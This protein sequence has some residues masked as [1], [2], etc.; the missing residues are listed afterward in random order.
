[1]EFGARSDHWPV[2]MQTI[3]PYLQEAIP[4]SVDGKTF[5][6]VLNVERTFWEKATILHM[7]AHYPEGKEIQS[8]QSRHYYDMYCLI[9]SEFCEL[10]RND[11]ELLKRVADHKTIYFRSGWACYDK[12]SPG[13][14]KLIPGEEVL[15][16]MAD[17]YKA[18]EVMFF[19]VPPSWED[20]LGTLKEF[21]EEF[22]KSQP[23]FVTL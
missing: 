22:N 16:K 2:S 20:I 13:T 7:Y 11:I 21:E 17:D 19:D 5:I 10:A 12:A 6:R 14:L 18:M 9:N 23:H 1:M 15:S 3:K 8:R 4:E